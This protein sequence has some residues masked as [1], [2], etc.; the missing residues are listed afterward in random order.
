MM[1]PGARRGWGAPI[2]RG[3]ALF[4][5]AGSGATRG[6][7]TSGG[8]EKKMSERERRN[9]DEDLTYSRGGT[10]DVRRRRREREREREIG[11]GWWMRERMRWGERGERE[12]WESN[13]QRRGG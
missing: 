12:S 3:R 7:K 5:K 2:G 6:T 11:G 8:A 9:G 4:G 10:F 13:D 1:I